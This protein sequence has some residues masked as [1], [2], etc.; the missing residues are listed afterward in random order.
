[1]LCNLLE[2]FRARR[3]R[4]SLPARRQRAYR[5]V[6]EELESR[7]T[8]AT[9]PAGFGEIAVASG[10]SNATAM[11]IAPDGKLF[12][13]EQAGTMEVWQNGARLQPNFF[14]NTPLAVNSDG[15]R[16]LLGIAFDPNYASNRFV[17]VNYTTAASVHSRVSRF[18]ANATGDLALAGSEVALLDVPTGAGTNHLGGAIHF[19]PDGK[20]YIAIGDN[21][22]SNNAQQLTN[23]HGKILRINADGTIPSDN[24]FLASTTGVNRAIW[25][26]GLRNPFTFS[27]QPGTG[28]MFI[29]DV[30]SG[31]GAP[32]VDGLPWEEINDGFAGANFDWPN[33]EGPF[34][35]RPADR[36]T[37]FYA[38]NHSAFAAITGGAFY[39][40]AT[41]PFP[42]QY[43]GDYFFADLGLGWIRHIDLTTKAVADFATGISLPVDL[44]VGADGSLYY[45]TRGA[46]QVVR[47]R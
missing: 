39:N 3:P 4:A 21:G 10:L 8:P 13:T 31:T 38:Y 2:L 16:G 17:Y 42:A 12:V 7:A 32:S 6:L 36:R 45:L 26:V 44:K 46:G 23:L 22:A 28:R 1:M 20:L 35:G 27:F 11:E 40:P 9:L 34:T 29:N 33:T 18:T 14:Q 25:A 37:P 15:E 43:L 41:N 24:P 19:G 47:V 30:G 5:P